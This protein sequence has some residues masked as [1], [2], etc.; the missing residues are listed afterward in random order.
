MCIITV[1]L[2]MCIISVVLLTINCVIQTGPDAYS[3]FKGIL[4]ICNVS[5]AIY[6]N[7]VVKLI[8]LALKCENS[9]Q[10][11]TIIIIMI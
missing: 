6:Y 8:G 11:D 2:L 10:T 9:N 3:M 7:Y 4:F 5:D 1:V